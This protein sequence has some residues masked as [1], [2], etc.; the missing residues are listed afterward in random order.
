MA[1]QLHIDPQRNRRFIIISSPSPCFKT[2]I[3]KISNVQH[4]VTI[5]SLHDL[6][7]YM[8][9]LFFSSRIDCLMF[10]YLGSGPDGRFFVLHMGST[11]MTVSTPKNH[12]AHTFQYYKG[13]KCGHGQ[14]QPWKRGFVSSTDQRM[15]PPNILRTPN[16]GWCLWKKKKS[17]EIGVRELLHSIVL[18]RRAVKRINVVP[19]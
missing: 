8:L 12:L 16:H 3:L 7:C 2:Y 10:C 14:S 18:E 1:W 9:V 15:L 6:S 4:F 5:T 17:K 13:S 11:M 19:G